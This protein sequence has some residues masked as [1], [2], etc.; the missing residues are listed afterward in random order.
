MTL[1]V[2]FQMDPMESIDIAGDKI[3]RASSIGPHFY[4]KTPSNA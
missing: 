1:K 3:G 4:L 2:A